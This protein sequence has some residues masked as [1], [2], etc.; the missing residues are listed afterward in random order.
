MAITKNRQSEET[1]TGM[2]R[3]AFPDKKIKAIKELTEGMCNVTYDISFEDGS[4]SI[5][6][7]AS[8]DRS[9]NTS[10]EINLMKAEITAM[11]LVSEKCSFK[12]ADVQYYDTSKTICDG[13]YFFMEKLSG[14][15]LHLIREKM[16][17][18]EISSI[19]HEIGK[20]SREGFPGTDWD[21]KSYVWFSWRRCPV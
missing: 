21:P 20:A 9:G 3:A 6:K 11:K 12:V 2:A 13:D 18:E 1:I 14:D 4:E 10:N 15:N 17:E 8:K 19:D 16:S 7:I 5:L